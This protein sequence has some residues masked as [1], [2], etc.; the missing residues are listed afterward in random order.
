MFLNRGSDCHRFNFEHSQFPIALLRQEMGIMDKLESI[1]LFQIA[2]YVL[3]R[4]TSQRLAHYNQYYLR[5]AYELS[6]DVVFLCT[7]ISR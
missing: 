3:N 2:K 4:G 1:L 5:L 6:V 7:I